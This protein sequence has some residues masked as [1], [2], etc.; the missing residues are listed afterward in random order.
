VIRRILR[1]S[2]LRR[3]KCTMGRE[4]KAFKVVGFLP[5]LILWVALLWGYYVYV[6]SFCGLYLTGKYLAVA[7]KG[8][9]LSQEPFFIRELEIE[10]RFE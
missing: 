1:R 3:V 9:P 10:R 6:I 7:S 8:D 2:N 4:H 5:V